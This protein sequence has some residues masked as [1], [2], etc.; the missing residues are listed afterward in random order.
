MLVCCVIII[1]I[2]IICI[3]LCRSNNKEDRIFKEY[4]STKDKPY[5]ENEKKTS[6]NDL[7]YF[8]TPIIQATRV[9]NK[10]P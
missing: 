10:K 8:M 7:D 2:V 4:S 9:E 3:L 5:K 6:V 1:C